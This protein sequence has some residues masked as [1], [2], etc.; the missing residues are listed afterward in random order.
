MKLQKEHKD[1]QKEAE[2]LQNSG[3]GAGAGAGVSRDNVDCFVNI[4]SELY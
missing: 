4:S 2:R 3:A 1:L